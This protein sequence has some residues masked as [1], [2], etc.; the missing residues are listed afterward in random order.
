MRSGTVLPLKVSIPKGLQSIP[1]PESVFYNLR[2]FNLN[3]WL[4]CLFDS[5]KE[6][7]VHKQTEV[8]LKL[9]KFLN[10]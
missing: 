9:G 3:L 8:F 1:K 5:F 7:L 10:V 4:K 2:N 6:T